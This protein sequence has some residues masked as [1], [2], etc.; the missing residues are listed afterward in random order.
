MRLHNRGPAVLLAWICGC[1]CLTGCTQQPGALRLVVRPEKPVFDHGEP[2]VLAATIT[3]AKDG[4]ALY[5]SFFFDV[6]IE[7]EGREIARNGEFVFICGTP[8]MMGM[9]FTSFVWVGR[10]LDV[11]DSW[12]EFLVLREGASITKRL[13]IPMDTRYPPLSMKDEGDE[14]PWHESWL[15]P[16]LAPGKYQVTCR[17]VNK[18]LSVYP[19]PMFWKPYAPAVESTTEFVVA[20]MKSDP[21]SEQHTVEWLPTWRCAANSGNVGLAHGW[22]QE[23][24]VCVPAYGA[25]SETQMGVFPRG[26]T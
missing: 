19:D 2:V 13:L 24:L 16:P 10:L 17:L 9:P 15:P 11:G 23:E 21:T 25:G 14:E 26:R 4:A 8:F 6:S 1:L 5:R 18:N 12:G 20:D 3:S 22:N 7:Q